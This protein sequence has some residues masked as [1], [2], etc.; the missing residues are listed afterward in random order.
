MT[1]KESDYG[2]MSMWLQGMGPEIASPRLETCLPRGTLQLWAWWARASA[3]GSFQRLEGTS[4]FG[5]FLSLP[6]VKKPRMC[7]T[8]SLSKLPLEK[9]IIKPREE[10]TWLFVAPKLCIKGYKE[11][12]AR[13]HPASCCC[14][15]QAARASGAGWAPSRGSMGCSPPGPSTHCAASSS[16]TKKRGVLGW[17]QKEELGEQ[18]N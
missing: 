12:P 17:E 11:K 16:H 1:P 4:T 2:C 6:K 5:P 9:A 8:P 3:Q 10:K 13:G 14:G 7:L 18:E 15:L